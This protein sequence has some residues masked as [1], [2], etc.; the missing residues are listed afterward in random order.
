MVVVTDARERRRFGSIKP[1]GMAKPT[2][3]GLAFINA[4]PAALGTRQRYH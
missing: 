3:L 4:D 2:V 1:A